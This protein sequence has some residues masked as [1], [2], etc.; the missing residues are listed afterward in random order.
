MYNTVT[1]GEDIYTL[2]LKSKQFTPQN[3]TLDYLHRNILQLCKFPLC[4][5]QNFS[6]KPCLHH[7]HLRVIS[8]QMSTL[9]LSQR[10]LKKIKKSISARIS[11]ISMCVCVYPA[12]TGQVSKFPSPLSVTRNT[13]NIDLSRESISPV[14]FNPQFGL[15][16]EGSRVC[17]CVCVSPTDPGNMKCGLLLL[18]GLLLLQQS[19]CFEFV[20]DGEWEGETV[21]PRAQTQL[22]HFLLAYSG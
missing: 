13:T 2:E 12:Y 20:I 1:G 17:V 9:I 15:P 6:I 5:A 7:K 21:S 11:L 14:D 8:N 22:L 19:L 10:C 3:K 4:Q 18:L 16:A